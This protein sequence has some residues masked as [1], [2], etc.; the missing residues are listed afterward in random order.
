MPG[1]SAESRCARG[2][3]CF[4]NGYVSG[5]CCSPACRAA[6]GALPAFGHEFNSGGPGGG[7]PSPRPR[8]PIG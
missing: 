1:Y 8:W 3:G 6:H 4:T 7:L 2:V 5:P